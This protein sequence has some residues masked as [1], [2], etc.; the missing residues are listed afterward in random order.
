MPMRGFAWLTTS[1]VFLSLE[2]K[3]REQNKKRNETEKEVEK[4]IRE[5][6]KR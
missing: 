5:K 4:K 2:D 3:K 6:M 1:K